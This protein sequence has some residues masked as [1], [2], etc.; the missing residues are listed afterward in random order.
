MGCR[1]VVQASAPARTV[2]QDRIGRSMQ[3]A[4]LSQMQTKVAAG[5]PG[6]GTGIRATVLTCSESLTASP[7]LGSHAASPSSRLGSRRELHRRDFSASS[8]DVQQ[9]VDNGKFVEHATR[10]MGTRPFVDAEIVR[11]WPPSAFRWRRSGMVC[12]TAAFRALRVSI[13]QPLVRP[14]V[15]AI[16]VTPRFSK[17]LTRK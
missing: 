9:R 3:C 10:R 16:R 5:R 8:G 6:T 17:S 11:P 15:N 2:G 12:F 13:R 7:L 4:A 14:R 1:Q